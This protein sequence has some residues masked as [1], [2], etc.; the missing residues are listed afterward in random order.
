LAP[1]GENP[2]NTP[3]VLFVCTANRVRSPMAEV[4]FRLILEN[5]GLNPQ[6]WWIESAGTWATEGLP[7]FE[8]VQQVL[9]RRGMDCGEHRSRAVTQ[10][11]IAAHNLVLVMEPGHKEALQAEFPKYASKVH[12]LSELIGEKF[13]I[14]DPAGGPNSEYENTADELF[15]ILQSGFSRILL[16]AYNP[17]S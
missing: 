10:D 8:E 9:S 13:E 15:R 1:S 3:S 4:L 12:L 11:M 5:E 16:L 6:D 7:V 2:F 14:V 17:E